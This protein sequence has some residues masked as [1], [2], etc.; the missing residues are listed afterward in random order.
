M[1]V[2]VTANLTELRKAM[3]EQSDI[4]VTTKREIS[5]I[6]NAFDGSKIIS[7]AGAVA[8][9]IQAMGGVANLTAGEQARANR[10]LDDAL[11]KY[12]ALGKEAPPGM[13]ALAAATR[14]VGDATET[15]GFKVGGLKGELSKF[16]G[17]LSAMGIN[18]SGPIRAI[19]EIGDMAGKSVKDIGLLGSAGAALGAGIAGWKIGRAI[20]DFF[21][22]D[23]AIGNATA[24][25]MGFGDMAAEVAGAKAEAFNGE[26]VYQENLMR[27]AAQATEEHTAVLSESAMEWNF[28]ASAVE[29][30]AESSVV[31]GDVIDGIIQTTGENIHAQQAYRSELKF[32]TETI[33]EQVDALDEW[34]KAQLEGAK[35][36]KVKA[37]AAAEAASALQKLF[38]DAGGSSD[39]G[40]LTSTQLAGLR[41]N[42]AA[43][44]LKGTNGDEN[45][46]KKL[47]ELEAAQA[48]GP[49][50]LF[51]GVTTA[52]QFSA[53]A[54]QSVLLAQLRQYF[55]DNSFAGGVE[56]YRGGMALVG[57]RGPEMVRLPRGADVIPNNQLGG[58][59]TIAPVLHFHGPTSAHEME[60][61][62]SDALLNIYRSGALPF[63]AAG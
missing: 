42:S 3:Q 11:D 47:A 56:N 23:E 43:N 31:Y 8:S 22:L 29:Q 6:S 51:E 14:G 45:V 52:E 41:G 9:Q 26:L 7:Q 61:A 59:V 48:R 39:V 58:S 1:V 19:G 12:K 20:A 2:K 35:A 32:T 18:L 49:R 44:M 55:Q 60:R 33:G 16:D 63:P 53:A 40:P 28:A 5:A 15:A 38:D 54:A 10:I 50:G 62:V 46:R 36:A 30:A 24:K 4:F 34:N 17:I 21:G 37:D 57:E 25:L 27:R 13:Q